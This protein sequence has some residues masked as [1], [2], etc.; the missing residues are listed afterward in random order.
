[1]LFRLRLPNSKDAV[2]DL[3]CGLANFIRQLRA[4]GVSGSHLFGT[5][6]NP[7]FI[8]LG[9]ALFRDRDTLDVQFAI[10]DMVDPGDVKL[11]SLE[12]KVTMV[13]A[14]SFFH[15]FD[16]TKQL[17][18]GLRIVKFLKSGTVNALIFGRQ[19]G[20]PGGAEAEGIEQSSATGSSCYIHSKTSFQRLWN[21]IG[22]ITGTRWAVDLEPDGTE[23]D[24]LP[25][26]S[27]GR[28]QTVPVKFTIVQIP[29]A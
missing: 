17:F 12:G 9:Y 7:L 16:W 25:G 29:T 24:H 6:V 27:E 4:D 15:L 19:A 14:D 13:H 10:G 28:N 26:P 3:G 1:M 20:V 23:A 2:L 11:A 22:S 5:D 8:D 18:I 21:E